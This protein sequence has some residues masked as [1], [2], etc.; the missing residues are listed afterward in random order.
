VPF[1][2]SWPGTL[3]AG[4][5][6][7]HPV[8]SLDFT[9]TFLAAAGKA[10]SKAAEFDGVNLLPFLTGK[11][12]APPH[13]SLLWRFT[14]SAAIRDGDWKLIRLP[15][16][17]PMLFNLRSDLSEQH[18]VALEN[19]DRTRDLLRRLGRWDV[20]LPHPLFLEG[21]VWKARQLDLYDAEYPLTQPVG[22]EAPKMIPVQAT[23]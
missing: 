10:A 1:L 23:K 22:G 13:D 15:D 9:P 11:N 16:R 2:M 5:Q 8:S 7:D 4:A 12:T 14:I 3:P 21:A 17:L 18:D 6:F 19:Q 20:E